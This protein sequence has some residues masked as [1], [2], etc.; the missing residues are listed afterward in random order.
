VQ[1]KLGIANIIMDIKGFFNQINS[2]INS[3]YDFYRNTNIHILLNT[4]T[5]KAHYS[6]EMLFFY[7]NKSFSFL[8]YG[9][10]FQKVTH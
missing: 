5:L 4:D 3:E 9:N 10:I 2:V 1:D 6:L 7:F 8:V